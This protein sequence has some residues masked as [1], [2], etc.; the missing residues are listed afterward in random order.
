MEMDKTC[1]CNFDKHKKYWS[2]S[3]QNFE[4]CNALCMIGRRACTGISGIIDDEPG[5]ECVY[6]Y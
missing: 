2:L 4:S 1:H 5:K 3:T 6:W